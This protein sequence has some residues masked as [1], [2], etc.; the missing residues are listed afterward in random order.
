MLESS[1]SVT[2]VLERGAYEGSVSTRPRETYVGSQVCFWLCRVRPMKAIMRRGF[3]A[4]PI[5]EQRN[6]TE[7]KKYINTH[8][9][10]HHRIRNEEHAWER[11]R[12]KC[13]LDRLRERCERR[14]LD[15][16]HDYAPVGTH[17]AR[18]V[19]A[20]GARYPPDARGNEE[21][22]GD[23]HGECERKL[24]FAPGGDLGEEDGLAGG[25][26]GDVGCGLGIW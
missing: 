10:L 22:R 20:D 16:D 3:M 24:G 13:E 14:T 23:V 1:V 2:A 19:R 7:C 8:D 18:V 4:Y 25:D 26:A 9:D 6:I 11:A 15:H 17:A 5:L 12:V 21:R